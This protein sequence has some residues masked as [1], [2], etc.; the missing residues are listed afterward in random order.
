MVFKLSEGNADQNFQDERMNRIYFLAKTQKRH[1]AKAV[2]S[3][4]VSGEA[5]EVIEANC[6]LS[7]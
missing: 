1:L 5:G 2:S 3:S 4:A 7:F 6:I